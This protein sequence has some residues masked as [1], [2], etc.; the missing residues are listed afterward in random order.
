MRLCAKRTQ[1]FF[2]LNVIQCFG[3]S[4]PVLPRF[5]P[6]VH[7]EQANPHRKCSP[8]LG[9]EGAGGGGRG[10]MNTKQPMAPAAGFFRLTSIR[11]N[12]SSTL[13]FLAQQLPKISLTIIRRIWLKKKTVS[14][15]QFLEIQIKVSLGW[16]LKT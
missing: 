1:F 9:R 10:W 14:R 11:H 5:H 12:P 16:Y 3:P 8:D 7:T 2:L 4:L 13:D 6:A 15:A